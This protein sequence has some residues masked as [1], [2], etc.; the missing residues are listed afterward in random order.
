MIEATYHNTY[1]GTVVKLKSGG[2]LMSV[3]EISSTTT[4]ICQ[5]FNVHDQLETGTFKYSCLE[6]IE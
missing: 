5:W 4:C 3:H 1:T 6:I 2:P